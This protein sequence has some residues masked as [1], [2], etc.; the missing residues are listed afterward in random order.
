MEHIV[1]YPSDWRPQSELPPGL[2][3]FATPV[4][5]KL[6]S[7]N[8]RTKW[9]RFTIAGYRIVCPL[10]MFGYYR[11]PIVAGTIAMIPKYI[12]KF[13]FCQCWARHCL[14][15][16]IPILF[17]HSLNIAD[18]QEAW[19]LPLALINSCTTQ[20]RRKGEFSGPGAMILLSL[21]KKVPYLCL[22]LCI[23]AFSTGEVVQE[24]VSWHVG[25][26]IAIAAGDLSV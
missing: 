19:A 4:V 16:E 22:F 18:I 5:S 8:V 24:V 26:N 20:C 2:T 1:F 15:F 10:I 12:N 6:I 14:P 17:R 13:L 25:Q 21:R 23:S 11:S 3:A 7:D 9:P